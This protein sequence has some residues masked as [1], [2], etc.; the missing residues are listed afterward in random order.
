M[1]KLYF[2]EY[3]QIA[4]LINEKDKTFSLFKGKLDNVKATF[5]YKASGLYIKE[6]YNNIKGVFV[7]V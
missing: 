3:Y 7:R 5:V 4:L 1:S 2:N 6:L